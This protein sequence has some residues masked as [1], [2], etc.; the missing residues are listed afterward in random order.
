MAPSGKHWF[1]LVCERHARYYSLSDPVPE[2]NSDSHV[3]SRW[4]SNNISILFEWSGSR[5]RDSVPAP[6]HLLFVS[7][8]VLNEVAAKGTSGNTRRFLSFVSSVE[9]FPCLGG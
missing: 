2:R 9:L 7:E 1:G 4:G 8:K 3:G 6:D 5:R